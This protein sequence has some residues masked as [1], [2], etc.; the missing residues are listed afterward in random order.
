MI[1]TPYPH[2]KSPAELG[3]FH[4]R[5]GFHPRLDMF[6]NMNDRRAYLDAYLSE[7]AKDAA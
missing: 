1:L 6:P 3:Q 4:A 5:Y 2:K 7:N